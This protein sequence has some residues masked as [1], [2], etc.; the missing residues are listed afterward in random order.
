VTDHPKSLHEQLAAIEV[1]AQMVIEADKAIQ[2]ALKHDPETLLKFISRKAPFP[3]FRQMYDNARFLA[4]EQDGISYL[5]VYG[6][7]EIGTG[8]G[9]TYHSFCVLYLDGEIEPVA[10]QTL[11]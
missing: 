10:I 2:H 1:Y 9:K 6:Q 4:C 3:E 8:S 5:T 7:V 11:Q